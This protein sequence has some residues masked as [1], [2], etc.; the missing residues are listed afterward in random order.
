[1]F[2]TRLALLCSRAIAF[3]QLAWV[4]V[5]ANEINQNTDI[6]LNLKGYLILKRIWS[7]QELIRIGKDVLENYPDLKMSFEL[8]KLIVER[9][10]HSVIS[11]RHLLDLTIVEMLKRQALAAVPRSA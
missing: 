9:A 11:F 7:D 8:L 4:S 3:T 10:D 2:Q 1:M 5:I 6:L